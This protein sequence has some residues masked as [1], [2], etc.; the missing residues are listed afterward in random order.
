M[1]RST[2]STRDPWT[3]HEE[4]P[5]A[6]STLHAHAFNSRGEPIPGFAEA[7]PGLERDLKAGDDAGAF[8]EGRG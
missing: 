7:E 1:H 2:A 6:L 5:G 8:G 3:D 4:T